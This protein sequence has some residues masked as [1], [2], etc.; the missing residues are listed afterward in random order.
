MGHNSLANNTTA[1]NNTAVGFNALLVNTTGTAGTA[2]GYGALD[3]NTTGSYN[4]GLGMQALT[5]NTTGVNNASVGFQSCVQSTTASE[6]SAFG[7]YALYSL[8]TGASNVAIGYQTGHHGVSTTTGAQNTFIGSYCGGS[9]STSSYQIVLGYNTLSVGA[10]HITLGRNT[11]N[12]RI[13]NA[14]TQNASWLRVSDERYKEN[15]TPNTDCGLAFINDLKPVT[16]TWKAKADIDNTLPDYDAEAAEP[17][18]KE[19]M[20]GLI[21]QEVKESLDKHNITDFGGWDKEESSG[22][23]AISQ[24]MFVHP[25]IKAVQELSA[26]LEAAEAR[27]KTLEES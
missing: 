21:A 25:L 15:I 9:S 20:Y 23:Q 13:Y 4:T 5:A 12:D 18:H 22:I 14:Y 17:E 27:I 16:F 7:T 6:T 19:K 1:S 3:S 2:L 11:G 8:T 24:E 10:D 26:K